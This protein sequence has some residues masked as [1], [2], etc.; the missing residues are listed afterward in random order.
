MMTLPKVSVVRIKIAVTALSLLLFVQTAF[1]LVYDMV[2]RGIGDA[3]TAWTTGPSGDFSATSST[4]LG[5][6]ALQLAAGLAVLRGTRGAGGLLVTSSAMTVAFR[7]PPVW[8]M[9]LDSPSDRWFGKLP[10]PSV[11]AVGASALLSVLL[12]AALGALL[13]LVRHLENEAA[14]A[15]AALDELSG[16]GIRPMKVTASASGLLLAVLNVFYIGRN[17]ETVVKTESGIWLDRLF[18]KGSVQAVLG[19]SNSWQ[20]ASLT[21]LCG[22]GMFLALRRRPVAHGF[23]LGLSYFMLPLAFASLSGSISAGTLTDTAVGSAQ[24]ALELVGSVAVVG[25]VFRE[26]RLFRQAVRSRLPEASNPYAAGFVAPPRGDSP[27]TGSPVGVPPRSDAVLSVPPPSGSTGSGPERSDSAES[28]S[29]RREPAGDEPPQGDVTARAAAETESADTESAD[30][31]SADTA[32]EEGASAD[33]ASSR[34]VS[35]SPSEA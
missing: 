30:T 1:W 15:A 27:P 2:D 11:T 17:T 25:L 14:A 33:S 28:A 18:G 19:V 12:A 16:T 21:V 8:Y 6:A 5:L 31:E 34:S 32:S 35:V 20:W 24:N 9:L 22:A 10:G 26:S 29:A 23:S 7:L 4:D 3:W 13:L